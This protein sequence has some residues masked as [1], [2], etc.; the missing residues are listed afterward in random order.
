MRLLKRTVKNYTI[1]S[2]LVLIICTPLFY[3]AIQR[4]FIVEMEK[5]LFHHKNNFLHTV[6]QLNSE[7]DIH[8]Y[9]LLNEEFKLNDT[10]R[11]P[12]ADSLFTYTEYD[13]LG[14]EIVPYRALRTGVVFDNTHYELI[15]RESIVGNTKLVAAI[16]VIQTVLLVLMLVGFIL[17]NRK[18]S[19]VVWD[20]FYLILD[21]LKHYQIDKDLTIDLP[22]SPTFEFRDLSKAIVQL[23][24]KNR[25][26]FLIQKE[27]TENASHE[28]QTPLAI[29]RSKLELLMQGKDIT[30]E[31]A[32]L[33]SGL[34]DATDRIAR[35]NKNLLLL[36]QIENRQFPSRQEIV[37]STTLGQVLE[38][39]NQLAQDKQIKIITT[40]DSDVI[41]ETNSV[42]LEILIGNFISNALRHTHEKG[43]IKIQMKEDSFHVSNP[44]E[45]LKHPDKIFQRFNRE[46]RSTQGNG[47]GLAIAKKIC[48][49]E[50]FH[51]NYQ[52]SDGHHHFSVVFKP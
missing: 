27:F 31:Q 5:E 25:E 44:G 10:R 3:L 34:L 43:E 51:I 35:L 6:S 42:L 30:Q 41:V 19:K 23:V 15:I 20:P 11:W 26:A 40:V 38:L 21:K 17:I 22:H 36:S 49:I 1:Y 13:S 45:A 46:S 52:Y 12:I 32:E 9:Q 8:L 28:L 24:D 39:Y 7:N 2:V 29:F 16:V 4:L 47:L 37:V 14:K 33:I 48:E 18:L 50:G